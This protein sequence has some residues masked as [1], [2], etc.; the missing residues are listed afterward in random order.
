MPVKINI[1]PEKIGAKVDEAWRKSLFYLTEEI[2]N[3]CNKY[4]KYDQGILSAS[5]ATHSKPQ[6]GKIVWD[7]PYA[8]R[9]YWEIKTS[10]T[11]GRTW[12]WCETAKAHCSEKWKKQA[13]R[14]LEMNL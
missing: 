6:E 8:K 10:L 12:K 14:L 2:R 1:D 3:D 4:V 13:Q 5:S 7:T 9:Q 11:Q